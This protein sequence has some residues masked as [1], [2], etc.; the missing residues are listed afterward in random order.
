[1]A[2]TVNQPNYNGKEAGFFISQAMKE[3]GKPETIE[4]F[5]RAEERAREE[6]FIE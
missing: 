5:D 3:M 4:G 1:M 6:G 2:F